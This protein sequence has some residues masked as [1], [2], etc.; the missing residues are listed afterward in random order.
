M[1]NSQKCKNFITLAEKKL[2]TFHKIYA[3]NPS[4]YRRYLY[5]FIYYYSWCN[6]FYFCFMYC[7][8]IWQLANVSVL[9]KIYKIKS[10][11][12]SK[13]VINFIVC[14]GICVSYCC[15]NIQREKKRII[16]DCCVSFFIVGC[17]TYFCYFT[18]T[19]IYILDIIRG[20]N[21]FD[22]KNEVE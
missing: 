5:M 18:I 10:K 15:R 13:I 7:I 19:Y 16:G 11:P 1:L 22:K 14:I 12:L 17:H 8:Y 6:I 9:Y 21:Q 4:Y 2:W 20:S 3:F